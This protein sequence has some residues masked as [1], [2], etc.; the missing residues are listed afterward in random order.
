MKKRISK[1]FTILFVSLLLTVGI[2]L[3]CGGGD[4][5]EDYINSFFNPYVSKS[6]HYATFYISGESSGYPEYYSGVHEFDSV[7]IDEWSVFFNSKVARTDLKNLVYKSRIGEID[8]LIFYIKDNH[9]AIKP[10]LKNNSLLNFQD[11]VIAKEFL[12]YLGF[13]KRC[14]PFANYVP[15]WWDRDN[16]DDPRKQTTAMQKLIDGG[17]KSFSNAKNINI[18]QRYLFQLVRLMYNAG[19]YDNCI[20]FCGQ[21][22]NTFPLNNSI[23]YRTL[24]YLAG[25]HYKLKEYSKANYLYSVIYDQCDRMQ[26]IAF[27]NF[28]PQEEGDWNES[29]ALAKNT[30]EKTVLWQLLGIY[31]DP[32]RAM[33]EIYALDPKSDLVDLLLTRAVNI[34]EGKFL[35]VTFYYDKDTTPNYELKKAKVNQELQ[36]FIK[37]VAESKN[38]ANP[39]LWDLCT[40]YLYTVSGDFK[41]SETY[42]T[43]AVYEANNDRSVSDQVRMF[44]FVNKIELYERP[45]AKMEEDFAEELKWLKSDGDSRAKNV[46]AWALHRLSQKYHK[47]GDLVKAQCLDCIQGPGFYDDPQKMNSLI[48]LMDKPAKTNFETFI[49]GV[50]PFSRANL[51]E[52][53]AIN[54]VY[55]HRL[56]EALAKLEA[57]EGAGEETFSGDPFL[58]HINDCH[59]C[60]HLAFRGQTLTKRSF[61]KQMVALEVKTTKS[62]KEAASAYF[63][64]G[65]GYYNITYYGNGRAFYQTPLKNE[66]DI[67][68]CSKAEECYDK[69]MKLSTD[70]EFKAKCCFMAAKCEQNNFFNNKPKDFNGDFQAGNYFHLLDNYSQTNYYQD[71]IRECGYFKTYYH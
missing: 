6:D 59:D 1:K 54:L 41:A 13:A 53:Q 28:H 68:N 49:L 27:Q 22:L 10:K 19:D 34:D 8:T 63:N 39:Y 48:K 62:S 36:T 17:K 42:L 11:K 51:F 52:Y 47:F 20:S 58:I 23:K 56:K 55:Q 66:D 64:L 70:P 9:Y 33:K 14:E 57:C 50:H 7:N 37:Q 61:V 15:D 25:S 65:N 24:G 40:G 44:R 2:I 43:K 45:S 30:H 16:A 35:T 69:A 32:L 21:Y 26:Y 60:D 29:L 71:I 3:A 4:Y 18:R 5:F 46:Y 67:Y 31:A 38:S 12:F